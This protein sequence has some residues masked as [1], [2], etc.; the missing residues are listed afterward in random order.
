MVHTLT[1]VFSVIRL[2][3]LSMLF[4]HP[5]YNIPPKNVWQALVRFQNYI[6]NGEPDATDVMDQEVANDGNLDHHQFT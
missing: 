4:Q 6:E 3:M 5:L 1:V 2:W